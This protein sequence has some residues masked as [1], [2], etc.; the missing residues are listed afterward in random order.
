VG[1]KWVYKVRCKPDG[2]IDRYKARLVANGYNQQEGIDF[3]DTFSPVAKISIVKIFLAL[4][5]SYNWSISQMDINNAFL[6][7]DLF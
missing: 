4:A 1:I 5:T 7:G 3:F 2:T 6:N